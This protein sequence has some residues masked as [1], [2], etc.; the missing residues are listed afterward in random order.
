[1]FYHA[2]T[3][4]M[5]CNVLHVGLGHA[6]LLCG[7]PLCSSMPPF[8]MFRKG[9]MCLYF[10]VHAN[11]LTCLSNPEHWNDILNLL[12]Q[13]EMWF[14]FMYQLLWGL[15]MWHFLEN[16]SNLNLNQSNQIDLWMQLSVYVVV[17]I[18][19]Q[20]VWKIS[21]CS[22]RP[23]M[24]ARFR[25]SGAQSKGQ[26]ALTI[27]SQPFVCSRSL[28]CIFSLGFCTGILVFLIWLE[29]TFHVW[30]TSAGRALRL[31]DTTVHW[32]FRVCTT[33]CTCTPSTAAILQTF[34]FSLFLGLI[35]CNLIQLLLI[36]DIVIH[37]RS[38]DI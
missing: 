27:P 3:C 4:E 31:L 15:S 21:C 9:S 37:L 12:L 32:P 35:L 38:H 25:G 19:A 33:R 29:A 23:R 16:V 8:S 34:G 18:L 36:I 17:A 10:G 14:F 1:M 6:G 26:E 13:F 22:R 2:N 24:V 28:V 20:D 30:Q 5:C 7:L 11:M